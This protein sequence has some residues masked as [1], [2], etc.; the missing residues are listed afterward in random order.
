LSIAAI[1][2][3]R[4]LDPSLYGGPHRLKTVCSC[5]FSRITA[6]QWKGCPPG[7]PFFL[8][9]VQGPGGTPGAQKPR[10]R[11]RVLQQS[12]AGVTHE[13]L[14][15]LAVNSCLLPGVVVQFAR[16]ALMKL[17]HSWPG[18][19]VSATLLVLLMV[20]VV[21]GSSHQFRTCLGG[22]ATLKSCLNEYIEGRDTALTV[23]AALV[24]MLAAIATAYFT[25]TI[26]DINRRQ[27]QHAHKVERAYIS[28]GGGYLTYIRDGAQ[29]TDMT[30]FI[31]TVQNYGKTPGT[32][33][34]YA[35]FVVDRANLPLEP[36]YLDPGFV[37]TPFD[38]KY[39][40]GSPTSSITS[41]T[42]P[43]GPNP[44]AYGRF[45]Y[46]DIFEEEE[47]YFSFALPIRTPHDHSSLVGISKAYTKST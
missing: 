43:D 32:V 40:L 11:C 34:A 42:V 46:T 28:G 22:G 19:A 35:A 7:R 38:G 14:G 26:W 17:P 5:K 18:W 20:V 21:L 13:C 2:G 36:A 29:Y 8:V 12:R 47:H 1:A 24:T 10:G 33:T 44:I 16:G 6:R 3:I 39:Q 15:V 45:W 23:L 25:G 9:A 27:L 31:L 4:E 41:I 37:R 30:Q